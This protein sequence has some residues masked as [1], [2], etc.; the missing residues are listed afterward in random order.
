MFYR[1]ECAG[2][3]LEPMGSTTWLLPAPMHLPLD[4][5]KSDGVGDG[6]ALHYLCTFYTS[7]VMGFSVYVTHDSIT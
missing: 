1:I 3:H 6:R 7:L 5:S 2:T 4:W